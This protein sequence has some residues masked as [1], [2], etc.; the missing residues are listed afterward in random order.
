MGRV[1]YDTEALHGFVLQL[2]S[3]FLF[4][5][6]MVVGVG[7]MMFSIN[8]KLALFTLIPA[9]LVVTGSV[10][11]WRYIYPRYYRFWDASSKQAGMLSGTLSGIRVV[12]AFGQ[13]ERELE[14]FT[15]ISGHLMGTRRRV[16][17]CTATF[18]PFMALLF[19]LGG[20]IVWYIGGRDV[21][22]AQMTLGSLIAYLGYLVMF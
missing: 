13:E 19:Q 3:G 18:N 1:A 14:R 2:T 4:Q 15:R 20:W 6:I 16:D 21:L 5:I 12:K 8:V 10:L 22:S 17:M 11:F 9:P 7:I